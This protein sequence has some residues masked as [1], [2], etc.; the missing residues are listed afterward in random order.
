MDPG[1][2]LAVVLLPGG[3]AYSAIAVRDAGAFRDAL[4]KLARARLG[5]GQVS[6]RRSGT[7]KSRPS[8]PARRSA[9]RW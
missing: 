8:A 9:R 7:L 4:A 5:A 2:G 1:R 6:T 3:H